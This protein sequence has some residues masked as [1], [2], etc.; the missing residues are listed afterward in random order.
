MYRHFVF[1]CFV[2]D[3]DSMNKAA[4]NVYRQ[5]FMRT[6]V[7]KPMERILRSAT[8][9]SHGNVLFNS[10]LKITKV[11]RYGVHTWNPSTLE[12]EATEGASVEGQRPM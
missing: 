1:D 9:G 4:I 10:V 7:F 12:A 11:V 6:L 2:F 5:V 8:A 3:C